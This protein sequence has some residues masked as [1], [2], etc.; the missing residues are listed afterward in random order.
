MKNT[1]IADTG[2][3]H[4]PQDWDR[5]LKDDVVSSQGWESDLVEECGSGHW[6]A[7]LWNCWKPAP[8]SAEEPSTGRCLAWEHTSAAWKGVGEVVQG[9]VLGEAAHGKVAQLRNTLHT[10]PEPKEG[11]AL[12]QRTFLLHYTR[13]LEI[14]AQYV[15][16]RV[17]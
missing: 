15:R 12:D 1:E 5:A 17:M 11:S 4:H 13:Q 10:L 9:R 6:G 8:W 14:V 2:S 7:A 16:H 3:S